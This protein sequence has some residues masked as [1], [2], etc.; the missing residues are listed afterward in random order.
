MSEK[1][2]GARVSSEVMGWDRHL[3]SWDSESLRLLSNAPGTRE[4]NNILL[5]CLTPLWPCGQDLKVDTVH[6]VEQGKGWQF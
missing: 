3:Q 2:I 4:A 5:A 6:E 1:M